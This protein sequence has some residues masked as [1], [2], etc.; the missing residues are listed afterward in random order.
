MAKWVLLRNG[1]DYQ[2]LSKQLGVDPV[3]V[4]LMRNRGLSTEKE[5]EDYL[6]GT[7]QSLHA[8]ALLHD[9]DKAVA[10]LL[11]K[12]EEGAKI[13]I[14]GDYDIDGICATYILLRGLEACG[15]IVDTVIPHRVRDGYGL[16]D[17]LIDEAHEDGID[18][19]LTCDNGIAAAPQIAHANALGMSVVVTDHHEVPFEGEGEARR[20]ILPPAVA[21]VD[22]KQEACS[23]PFPG[24]C[25]AMV[26][27]KL[28]QVLFSE[29]ESAS[30]KRIA[31][32]ETA[33]NILSELMEFAA[34]ATVGDV[35]ELQ[36]ENRIIVR[37]GLLQLQH[38]KNP[39]MRALIEACG[40]Q[41]KPLFAYH[42]G[43]RL[44]P[45]VNAVGRLETAKKAL[46]LFCCK[47]MDEARPMAEELVALNEQR[48]EMTER[49]VR[50]AAA[51]I[52]KEGMAQDKVLVVYL[53]DCH[54]SLAGIIA[55]RIRERYSRPTFVLTKAE[56]GVKGSGRS[57]EAYSMYEEISRCKHLFTQ[58][59]GHK[60]A[61]GLSMPEENVGLFRQ[62]LNENA[63]LT[64]DDFTE[65]V[66]IDADMPFSYINANLIREL[67]CIEPCGTG[68]RKPVFA[69]KDVRFCTGKILGKD[70]NVGR[71][72]VTED[73]Q[74]KYNLVYFG[75]EK[76][77]AFD[78]F[79]EEH[80]GLAEKERLYHGGS[81][82]IRMHVLYEPKSDDYHG[83]DS[84]QIEMKDYCV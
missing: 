79:L 3:I 46:S 68:N 6:H 1:A 17:H 19:I 13:R 21:V 23:Y 72:T 30:A 28:V 10:F 7:L 61:A 26:A 58:Y 42:I 65:T 63:T 53:P 82:A 73:G 70:H 32:H 52:E 67:A 78:A 51:I 76:L 84:F 43:F 40:L 31:F 41:D 8:P 77:E 36:D 48:K 34:F 69:R 20:E 60:M 22:P 9:M 27:Y 71:Y 81:S 75:A 74:T 18:T 45:C 59:G 62:A 83:K 5:M 39:G 4:R 56:E 25:G 50:D 47:D 15:G 11:K 66:Y 33:E 80:F 24:I 49:G 57:I 55:G 54:E 29:Y 38:S 12:T 2:T 16:N 64:D 14:I 35:M 37:Q 44:G